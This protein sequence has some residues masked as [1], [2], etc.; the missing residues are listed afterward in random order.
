[1]FRN[2]MPR[3]EILT[4]D[5]LQRIERGWMRIV[6][7][8]GIAFDHPEALER[9]RDAGQVVDGD[10]VRFD[11]DF[12]L[13]HCARAP[14]EF[15]LRA[16][17][18]AHS[19]HLGGDRMVFAGCAGMPFYREGD[20]RRDATLADLERMV[21]LVQAA[22][23]LDLAAMP[24]VEPND[25]PLDSRHLDLALAAATLT[26]KP[27][28]FGALSR[29]NVEDSIAMVRLTFG[30]TGV[31]RAPLAA[32]TDGAGGPSLPVTSSLFN[33]NVNSPLRYD[34]RMLEGLLAAA[35]A[36]QG[37][38][39]TP[40]L[41]MGA[42][43]PV[44]TA[45]ALAQQLA[46]ALTGVALAQLVRPGVP[47][48]LGSFLSTIDMQS[49]SPAFGGPESAK[50]LFASG[51]LARRYRLPWRSGGGGLTSSQ[52]V[53][54]QAAYESQNT[55]TAAFLAGANLLVHSAGWLES[56]L[57]ASP[58]KFALD[59]EILRVLQAQF[60][61]IGVEDED[62]AFDA[63]QEVGQGGHFLGAAH[64][65]TRFRTC[66]YRSPLSSTENFERWTARGARDTT[67][68]AGEQW[69]ALLDGYEQPDLDVDIRGRL[70]EYV[71]RR[72]AELG[73]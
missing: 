44:T 3:Y 17:N 25:T 53:D 63:H 72:R 11:P 52:T 39:V 28:Y 61:P 46:E 19:V 31:D 60:T 12:V 59:L 15:T 33:I 4:D 42:M 55:M 32:A 13:E 58:D 68:R 54:A 47:V 37:C 30:D 50:G 10:V 6:Q 64:T 2:V 34:E 57:V 69:R 62:L 43:A 51:Q 67:A 29:E 41:L 18:P 21:R 45:A 66:F 73:D 5:A 24:T 23:E 14:S 65:M 22:P 71:T 7:E 26:D 9:L 70:Q 48:V 40:F 36:G 16:R 20:I 27:F 56:G 38:V 35:A 1:M 8:I 49:G